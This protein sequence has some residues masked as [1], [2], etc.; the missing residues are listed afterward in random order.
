MNAPTHADHITP[1][2]IDRADV[3]G[4]VVRLSAVA[5]AI[6]SRYDYP[7]ILAHVLGE[8]LVVAAMLSANLKQEGIF[9][10]Q[11]RGAGPVPLL[12]VDAAYGGQLRGFAEIN[13]DHR[14]A[15]GALSI[16]A[17]LQQ[18]FGNDAYLAITL[19]PGAGMQRYQGVV[20]LEGNSITQALAHYFTNS[21][22]VDVLFK[23][24]V[25]R[26]ALPGSTD[27]HWVAA[28]LMI[29]RLPPEDAAK[30]V[31]EASDE[32]WRYASAIA[33]T[34]KSEELLDP[35]LDAPSLLLRL[36]HEEG[37]WVQDPLPV[38]AGCRC[39]RERIENLLTSMPA[40]D[41]ADMVVDGQV[42]VHCQFCNSSQHFTPTE[43]GLSV[44]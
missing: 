35:L 18:L 5:D 41:R 23:L 39:S 30:S 12:V 14:A 11:I 36:Y 37:V 1:F 38:D 43:I 13:E 19:D 40:T 42:S 20:A 32:G 10:L 9:T 22:Q 4:R 29:E 8:L 6:L 7:P 27:K 25:A 17:D 3:R 34:I 16:P 2:M 21:Q 44:N 33:E 26:Q 15:L 28:G 31:E 24:A